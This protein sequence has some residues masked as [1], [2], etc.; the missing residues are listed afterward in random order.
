MPAVEVCAD[1]F[2]PGGICLDIVGHHETGSSGSWFSKQHLV[3]RL[4]GSASLDFSF[5]TADRV[6]TMNVK[7]YLPS[8]TRASRQAS[9]YTGENVDHNARTGAMCR[10][11]SA[12]AAWRPPS[13]L[14]IFSGLD[15]RSPQLH[16]NKAKLQ[17]RS[18][19][20]TSL[21]TVG[22]RRRSTTNAG[23]YQRANAPS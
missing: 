8:T 15:P 21:M 10:L 16:V 22:T 13:E 9:L 20:Y 19:V 4:R 23:C 18:G 6:T 5:L 17:R 1:A 3:V 14:L 7:L 12:A 11:L 2:H